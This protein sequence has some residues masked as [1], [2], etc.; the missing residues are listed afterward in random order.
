M[1]T[2]NFLQRLQDT[3]KKA[4]AVVDPGLQRDIARLES[5]AETAASGNPVV[6]Q[7]TERADAPPSRDGQQDVVFADLH[8]KASAWLDIF[9]PKVN[10]CLKG[11][12]D[13]IVRGDQESLAH[14]ALS[15]RRALTVLA[16]YVEPPGTERRRDHAGKERE[17]GQEQFKN[18]LYI[19]LGKQLEG[20]HRTLTLAELELIEHQ[21]SPFVRAIGKAVHADSPKDDLAQVYATTWSVVAQIIRCAE[22]AS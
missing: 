10:R 1:P 19:Y 4:S 11:A 22:S 17:V 13:A 3:A 8:S 14:A 15:L 12:H 20:N 9:C 7:R 16:D 2:P 5:F 21:L 18:R 6:A